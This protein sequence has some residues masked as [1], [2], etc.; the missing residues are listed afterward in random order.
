MNISLSIPDD[1]ARQM[2]L[3]WHD[4]PSYAL[5]ALAVE[6]YRRGVI[7]HA[8]VGRLLGHGSRFDTDRFLKES[9]AYLGYS[10][11]DL[12]DDLGALGGLRPRDG[13]L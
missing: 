10:I 13:D 8:Q 5:E 3:Q 6:A 2:Q 4:L 11:E 12:K 1:V 9:K 7:T